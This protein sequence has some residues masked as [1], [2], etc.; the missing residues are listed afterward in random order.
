MGEAVTR[1]LTAF[2]ED[3]ARRRGV[4]WLDLARDRKLVDALGPIAES[5]ER[6]AYVPEALKGLVTPL[7]VC[8]AGKHLI[9]CLDA[10]ADACV[11]EDVGTE[12]LLARLCALV[13]SGAGPAARCGERG[14][15]WWRLRHVVRRRLSRVVR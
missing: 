15:P 12:E 6:R 14:A 4:P 7:V 11:A 10:G 13:R 3:E 9:R 5:L 1:G 8:A 2:S